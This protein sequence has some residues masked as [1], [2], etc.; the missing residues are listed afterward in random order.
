MRRPWFG[1][2]RYQKPRLPWYASP[3]KAS[4]WQD[5]AFE[6][7]GFTFD[8]SLGFPGEGPSG[9]G[10]A[11][12]TL[13]VLR[14]TASSAGLSDADVAFFG[15]RRFRATY[16]SALQSLS[17]PTA[18]IAARPHMSDSDR[19]DLSLSLPTD[20]D[21]CNPSSPFD[22][23]SDPAVAHA[24]EP[25]SSA[26]TS[27]LR[28]GVGTRNRE[29]VDD[30]YDQISVTNLQTRDT[31]VDD[32]N[33][34]LAV[35][36]F[37]HKV[38]KR[39][40][41]WYGGDTYEGLNDDEP[42]LLEMT[43]VDPDVL[44]NG[45]NGVLTTAA[46][47]P[48]ECRVTPITP[49]TSSPPS[50]TPSL[51]PNAVNPTPCTVSLPPTAPTTQPPTSPGR[52]QCPF[53]DDPFRGLLTAHLRSAH[54][55]C[56]PAFDF[57]L[58]HNL[59]RCASCEL[60]YR[61]TSIKSH[62]QTCRSRGIARTHPS[63]HRNAERA[64]SSRPTAPL[65]APPTPAHAL[66]NIADT[67]PLPRARP[68]SDA[69]WTW[70]RP[71]AGGT[72]SWAFVPMIR[73][74]L[75]LDD[76]GG[77]TQILA[78]D[79][80]IAWANAYAADFADRGLDQ[81]TTAD[82][83]TRDGYIGAD[84]QVRLLQGPAANG[85]SNVCDRIEGAF[86]DF[87]RRI[88]DSLHP[89]IRPPHAPW[90]VTPASSH[91]PPRQLEQGAR[92]NPDP[93]SDDDTDPALARL[94]PFELAEH[95][96]LYASLP[97]CNWPHLVGA[98]RPLAR[99]FLDAHHDSDLAAR[100]RAIDS[101]LSMPGQCLVRKRGGAS[102]KAQAS[103]RRGL[104]AFRRRQDEF[105]A[106]CALPA[107]H[108]LCDHLGP[109]DCPTPEAPRAPA[110]SGCDVDTG[111]AVFSDSD[112]ASDEHCITDTDP[113]SS[114]CD[115]DTGA[116]VFPDSDHASDERCITDTDNP[117]DTGAAA[118]SDN[119][120][121]GDGHGV[122]DPD[123]TAS[124]CSQGSARDGLALLRSY[125]VDPTL[126]DPADLV[127]PRSYL[128]LSPLYDPHAD[129]DPIE[130]NLSPTPGGDDPNEPS[131]IGLTDPPPT[132]GVATGGSDTPP[133]L[134][135][136]D[137]APTG[138]HEHL[139]ICLDVRNGDEQRLV[140]SL[141]GLGSDGSS[142][143]NPP[144]PASPR[145]TPSGP[146][147]RLTIT[148]DTITN[149]NRH[150]VEPPT[151]PALLRRRPP[152]LSEQL[153]ARPDVSRCA[154]TRAAAS[155]ELSVSAS[156]SPSTQADSC[157]TATHPANHPCPLGNITPEAW[158]GRIRNSLP[159]FRAG[160]F[161]RGV[162]ALTSDGFVAPSTASLA[163]LRSKQTAAP[164]IADAVIPDN[165]PRITIDPSALATLVSKSCNGRKGG[166]SGWTS[167]LI[168]ALLTD[169]L[170][171]SA[172]TLL[173]ELIANN[174][175]DAHSRR[176]L[177]T[178]VMHGLPK[179][180]NDVRPLAIGEEFLR[181]A[182]RYCSDL[183]RANLPDVFDSIQ[184][185][186][187]P[188][189]CERAVQTLQAAIETGHDH[190]HIALHIDSSN[191]FNAVDRN[192]VLHSFFGCDD[193]SSTWHVAQFTYGAPSPLLVRDRGTVVDFYESVNG[194]KQ[195]DVLG[196]LGYCLA[197]Q[198]ALL[199]AMDGLPNVTA[200]AICDDLT[201]VGPAAD[202]FLAYDRYLVLARSLLVNVNASKTVVQIPQADIAEAPLEAIVTAA[203]VRGLPVVR[204]NW[205]S[206]GAQLGL[207]F[208]AMAEWVTAKLD[209]QRP[210]LRAIS[211]TTIP[212]ATAMRLAKVCA[213]PIPTYIMRCLPTS[214]TLDGLAAFDARL[215]ASLFD[216]LGLPALHSLPEGAQLSICQPGRNGG[217]GLR[218]LE[219]VAHAARWASAAAVAPDLVEFI[220]PAPAVPP[221]FVLDRVAC[222]DELVRGGIPVAQANLQPAPD[223]SAPD[224]QDAINPGRKCRTYHV[225]PHPDLIDS[226]YHSESR[227]PELQHSLTKQLE[228]LRLAR[229]RDSA[230]C[231]MDDAIRLASCRKTRPSAVVGS[232]HAMH[233]KDHLFAC[234]VR[235]AAGL[236][237]VEHLQRECDL[238]GESLTANH[239]L[240]NPHAAQP[241]HALTCEKLRRK[242]ITTRHN[243]ALNLLCK[244]ARSHGVLCRQEPKDDAH[245][246]P[247]GE[248]H[249]PLSTALIDVSGTHPHAASYRVNAVRGTGATVRAR[250]V[251][252]H[253]KYDA[254]AES[255]GAAFV[256]FVIDTYGYIGKE[257]LTFVDRIVS[258]SSLASP[259]A[260][261]M[262]KAELLDE[263]R[264]TWQRHNGLTV[265]QWLMHNRNLAIRRHRSAYRIAAY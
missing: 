165:A 71:R 16:T 102:R 228:D 141:P 117:I 35:T 78:G 229:F 60:I 210:V 230:E 233:L 94:H 169:E 235:L 99:Q 5:V 237:P 136:L 98:F 50:P 253:R 37:R 90:R 54:A 4:P 130:L 258:Q 135:P 251:S 100:G 217:L 211:D 142:N 191:A 34:W 72:F 121:S 15:D 189:G 93:D 45:T 87:C 192:Q 128:D 153:A 181:L 208:H 17:A 52:V 140:G 76:N 22:R 58:R 195:G 177:T 249:L 124:S 51:A 82:L 13:D 103:V 159:F 77:K 167:E 68:P 147:Q 163:Q 180:N 149:D 31:D 40:V 127:A 161:R 38:T 209:T 126:A 75:G 67:I 260:Y 239:D 213:L 247:D 25:T 44:F 219:Q 83:F 246:V 74:A 176:L 81:R 241:W 79:D 11:G 168:R 131:A 43:A 154:H 257:G 139:T 36:V 69:V 214:A 120:H 33:A 186:F 96:V 262:T 9:D 236:D 225:P 203:A 184:F 32:S 158:S 178:S 27:R 108:M 151:E 91:H 110:S 202:V 175:L 107:P 194:V 188:G 12:P 21:C 19:R 53:C 205:E 129:L 234:F 162:Q 112:H 119:E 114:G 265:M 166:A 106:A 7:L 113:A 250:E 220:T 57:M 170:C 196:S 70:G 95:R 256:P 245:L 39:V 160:H 261:A 47:E 259:S 197:F 134:E 42:L 157:C 172:L 226:F 28:G 148:V 2:L 222:Y 155:V 123:D 255:A 18:I 231:S 201:L 23:N 204:G 122:S 212:A 150:R 97:Q 61:R 109:R 232:A 182:A 156:E 223:A 84:A 65:S 218:R 243:A 29:F 248:F 152:R 207:D 179:P 252:K 185:A 174:E 254:Y 173:I 115:V 227:I 244:F 105:A 41:L 264:V 63:A 133:R 92:R 190:D 24:R 14:R 240:A 187:T 66:T 200:R 86:I 221:P 183:D 125:Y 116:A 55:G 59:F 199:R 263:L 171:G 46:D 30:E 48:I 138:T 6:W 238:C 206:I 215:S 20:D 88:Q 242:A 73:C 56:E 8:S 143:N 10:H 193:L 89:P 224:S 1:R 3:S 26:P 216:R 146:S 145:N 137:N 164:P 144:R 104:D 49:P 64:Q 62:A 85:E 80:W 198:P 101:I 111:A 132:S 118:F